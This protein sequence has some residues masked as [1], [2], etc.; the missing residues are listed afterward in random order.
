MDRTRLKI[1]LLTPV[2]AVSL[3]A[4]GIN[5]I[6]TAEEEAKARWADVQN[7]YQR[8][9]DLIP[10][11]VATVQGDFDKVTLLSAQDFPLLPNSLLKR[12]LERVR[13]YELIE[14]TPV[15]PGAWHVG[16]RDEYFHRGGGGRRA[17]LACA[18]A[19]RGLRLFRRKRRL[20]DGFVPH[21]GSAWWSLSR[22]CVAE[23]LR[24]ADAHPR[25]LRF[26]RSVQCQDEMFYQTVV[27]HSRFA[28]R[29]L[30][31]NYRYIQWPEQ[32]ARNPKVLDAGDFERIRASNAFFCRKLDIQASADLMPRLMEWKE[33]RAAA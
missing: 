15:R 13:G 23:V 22:D 4:C 5:S 16:F 7:Q 12:E 33:S 28:D 2:A 27:M 17:G 10:N 18:L 29:V 14:T 1:A 6:P 3:T 32:G 21:G 26:F 11:L 20:P 8:R 19:N 24:L 30:S 31:D 9:A 25:L